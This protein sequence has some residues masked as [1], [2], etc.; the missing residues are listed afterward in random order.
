MQ[1]SYRVVNTDGKVKGDGFK[2]SKMS[3]EDV[4]LV[5]LTFGQASMLA[6][7]VLSLITGLSKGSWLVVLSGAICMVAWSV[8]GSMMSARRAVRTHL[9]YLDWMVTLPL[10]ALKLAAMARVGTGTTSGYWTGPY[11]ELSVA[12]LAFATIALSYFAVAGFGVTITDELHG[13][14]YV[15][16]VFTYIGSLGAMGATLGIIYTLAVQTG[17]ENLANILSFSIPWSGYAVVYLVQANGGIA[18]H[19]CDVLYTLLDVYSKA[20]FGL[21]TLFNLF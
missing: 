20:V 3:K 11:L 1:A 14:A 19:V 6:V 8:Y 13:S 5:A 16:F 12:L 7:G 9:R 10:L 4:S 2:Q 15:A 21:V 18:D 17:T